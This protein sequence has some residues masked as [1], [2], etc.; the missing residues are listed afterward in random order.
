MKVNYSNTKRCGCD[1]EKTLRCWARTTYIIKIMVT[2][3]LKTG[4][5]LKGGSMMGLA[6]AEGRGLELRS[7]H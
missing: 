4:K 1:S 3:M 7:F 2:G 5:N 6:S